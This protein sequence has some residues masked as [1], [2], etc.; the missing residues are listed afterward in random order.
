MAL[1]R[2]IAEAYALAYSAP[3]QGNPRP[4]RR[5]DDW[6]EDGQDPNG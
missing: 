6:P 2:T 5:H 1:C 3:F 4:S